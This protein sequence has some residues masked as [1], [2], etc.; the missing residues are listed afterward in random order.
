MS[1]L[2]SRGIEVDLFTADDV[3]GHRRTPLSYVESSVCKKALAERLAAYQP[4]AIHLHN[5]Y[6]TLSPGILAVLESYCKQHPARTVMTAHDHHLL[7]PNSGM[8]HYHR[9]Q[10]QPADPSRLASVAYLLTHRWDDRSIAHSLLK[11]FQHVWNYRLHKRRRVIDWV[12]CPS[13]YIKSMLD[14]LEMPTRLLPFPGPRPTSVPSKPDGPLRMVFSG[15]VEPE[16]GLAEFLESLPESFP[17][18][19]TIVGEGT[20]LDRCRDICT[21][22]GI[23]QRVEFVGLRPHDETMSIIG[24]SHLLVLG[25]LC[26]ENYPMSVLEALSLGTN[27][28]VSN[29][30]GTQEIVETS[31]IGFMFDPFDPDGVK[32]SLNDVTASFELGEL[33]Q[34]DVAAFLAQRS[35]AN[36]VAGLLSAYRGE[37]ASAQEKLGP[38]A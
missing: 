38:A 30:G 14:G 18:K 1:L 19:L 33:N 21:R 11:V 13:R 2:Q 9:G 6:H 37:R 34:F 36:Y 22:R 26:A 5:F 17:G 3:E 20:E 8:C 4:D 31:G 24:A 25:S 29:F 32:S 23:Q 16:K 15:R 27:V 12:L 7:C 35:E 10:M 28:L